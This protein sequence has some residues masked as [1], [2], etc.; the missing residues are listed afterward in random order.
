[1]S[2]Y[3]VRRH[4][5]LA[6]IIAALILAASASSSAETKSNAD[7][8]ARIRI[9]NFGRT[10]DNY[11]R[12]A[13]PD[14]RDYPDLAALGIKT[15]IDLTRDGRSDEAGLVQHAGMRF[16]RIPL[17]TSERPPEAA[18][19][20]FLKIV[21]DPANWP[22][23]VHCQGGRHRTGVMT[24]VYRMTKDGWNAN[25]AYDEM[26]QYHFEGFPGHPVLKSFVYDYYSK[27]NPTLP[28]LVRP[29]DKTSTIVQ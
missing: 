29:T 5:L 7:L 10:N 23:F 1:M 18:V 16:Y 20:Q 12:G 24:A 27:L 22:V 8:L 2:V 3:L 21:N 14:G 11:F 26:K 9:K 4:N 25:Q 6:T 17:T 13:Q 19:T 15:V 28:D